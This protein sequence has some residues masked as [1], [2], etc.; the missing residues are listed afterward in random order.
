[1]L[2]P[3]EHAAV[4]LRVRSRTFTELARQAR[5]LIPLTE[6]EMERL[7]RAV[8]EV[9][10]SG[11]ASYAE[12]AGELPA[13]L[14]RPF[15]AGL[16]RVGLNGSLWLAINLLKEEGRIL[17]L[18]SAK[19]LDT[20]AYVFALVSTILPELDVFRLRSEHANV[21]LAAL[22][23]TVEGPARVRD[24]A[25]WAGLHVTE[26]MRAVEALEPGLVPVAIA[27]SPEEFLISESELE[28]FRR[29][30]A[31]EAPSVSLIPYRDTYLKGQREIVNR[32]VREADF[33][34]PFSRWKG[35]LIND[36]VAT[37]VADGRVIGIWEW[38]PENG[39]EYHLF[40]EDDDA[41]SRWIRQIEACARKLGAF[42]QNDLGSFR[43]QGLAYG[44]NQMTGIHQLRDHWG[45][46][47]QAR[48]D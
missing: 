20:T 11:P 7:K 2:V 48:F 6:D 10:R 23:F 34:K 38:S 24:F 12:L 13:E 27:D 39:V 28:S 9:L 16:K 29:F 44:K 40:D 46:G 22:Y 1:M 26:A 30:R 15:P 33:D 19:R 42:I 36:P 3:R 37:I 31:S 25:W 18:Q 8:T 4:A 32:F 17:K 43:L 14:V 21:E 35:K 47:A 5:S 45:Q 41:A